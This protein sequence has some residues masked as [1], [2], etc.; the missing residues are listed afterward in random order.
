MK[1]SVVYNKNTG[2][3]SFTQS[4]NDTEDAEY[5]STIADV[6]ENRIVARVDNG[7]IILEDTPEVKEIKERLNQIRIEEQ[8]IKKKL[9]LIE[10]GIKIKWTH[11]MWYNGF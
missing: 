7:K 11:R 9:L 8:E 4:I 5:I 1:T 2:D 10:N 3:V 6:P